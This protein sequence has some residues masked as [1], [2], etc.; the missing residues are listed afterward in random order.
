MS[1]INSPTY[2]S[3]RIPFV[4]DGGPWAI[5]EKGTQFRRHAIPLYLKEDTT[6][7]FLCPRSLSVL[8][9][10]SFSKYVLSMELVMPA[11][12]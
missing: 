1:V 12:T 11:D 7:A 8:E 2:S 3:L 5:G 4:V 9:Y 10:G 6:A